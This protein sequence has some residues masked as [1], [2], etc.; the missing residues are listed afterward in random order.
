MTSFFINNPDVVEAINSNNY[1]QIVLALGDKNYESFY[2]ELFRSAV[3]L[4][5]ANIVVA[6]ILHPPSIENIINVFN[7]MDDNWFRMISEMS[8]F[9]AIIVP[10]EEQGEN[11]LKMLLYGAS[12][13]SIAT[14][15]LRHVG[16]RPLPIH[17]SVEIISN[18]L[19]SYIEQHGY[20]EVKFQ[21]ILDFLLREVHF[22][23]SEQEAY[24]FVINYQSE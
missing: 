1:V 22:D 15:Y 4:N 11:L 19:Q 3:I 18:F 2:C 23:S 14:R 5:K 20:S 17:L 6:L 21:E 12:S 10:P 24:Q 13:F 9:E 8:I 16:Y 7:M